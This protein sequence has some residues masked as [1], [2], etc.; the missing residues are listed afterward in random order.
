MPR[1][2][3]TNNVRKLCDCAKWKTCA[4]PW[5]LDYQRDKARYRDNL[6]KLIGRHAADFATAQD[7]ARRAIVAKLE[8]RDPKGLVP[9]DDPT[10]GQLLD[11]YDRE[12]PRRDRWQIGRI[13]AAE[14]MVPEGRRRLGDVR[15]S[16]VT[17]ETLKAFRRTRPL[18]AGN[19]DLAL[20]RA[21][22]NWAVL[23]GLLPRS[24]FRVG[25]VSAVRLAR[26]EA[27][28]RGRRR[29]RRIAGSQSRRC[30]STY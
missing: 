2:S 12:K 20:L 8:G 25:D 3:R 29:R 10:V 14:I 1:Q 6:D 7:E 24:P 23:G 27:R 4:H 26:E 17:A 22:C 16:T 19:R 13:R 9:S 28:R 5:Y 11:E 21:V 15:A 30:C 18:V